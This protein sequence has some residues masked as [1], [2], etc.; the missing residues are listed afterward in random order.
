MEEDLVQGLAKL[1]RIPTTSTIPLRTSTSNI[2][3]HPYHLHLPPYLKFFKPC[4]SL[5]RVRS[6]IGKLGRS[7]STLAFDLSPPPRASS[8]TS[9]RQKLPDICKT[10]QPTPFYIFSLHLALQVILSSLNL[11][12]STVQPSH[13]ASS[14]TRPTL[15]DVITPGFINQLKRGDQY[16]LV[17]SIVRISQLH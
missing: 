5:D 17:R 10:S 2:S 1:H 14:F 12:R 8:P 3:H 15:R 16:R 7:S 13:R 9:T 4:E 11:G 6:S